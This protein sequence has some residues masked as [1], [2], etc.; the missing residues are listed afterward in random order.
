V[1]EISPLGGGAIPKSYEIGWTGAPGT[2]VAHVSQGALT[3]GS[4]RPRPLTACWDS[5]VDDFAS[6]VDLCVATWALTPGVTAVK[7]S[8]PTYAAA[9]LAHPAALLAWGGVGTWRD[10]PA[11]TRR[12]NAWAGE[13]SRGVP[14]GGAHYAA[15]A[16]TPNPAAAGRPAAPISPDASPLTSWAGLAGPFAGMPAPPSVT[17]WKPTRFAPRGTVGLIPQSLWLPLTGRE[18]R[19]LCHLYMLPV[20][21]IIGPHGAGGVD[22]AFLTWWAT[23][24]A[25]RGGGT[26][27]M[28]E[29]E[30]LAHVVQGRAATKLDAA[31]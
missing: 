17:S 7:A 31:R 1:D 5:L 11:G 2:S 13:K 10:M 3:P 21:L 8:Y 15:P 27:S 26:V 9:A 22:R 20:P 25:L 23:E 14:G 28:G 12:M 30:I 19:G 18:R 4:G 29:D 6:A 24:W 16:Y